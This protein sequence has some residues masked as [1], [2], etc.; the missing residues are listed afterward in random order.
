MKSPDERVLIGEL[1]VNRRLD[2]RRAGWHHVYRYPW[3]LYTW[4]LRASWPFIRLESVCNAPNR[5]RD[6]GLSN[7]GLY[8]TAL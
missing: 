8:D 7:T 1:G 4:V 3:F 5:F 6:K 2:A